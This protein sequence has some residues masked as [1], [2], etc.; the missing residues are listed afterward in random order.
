M[1]NNKKISKSITA[2]LFAV[3]FTSDALASAELDRVYKLNTIGVL[4]AWDNVD[5]L[6]GD[7][8][9]DAYQNNLKQESRF[10]IQDLSKANQVLANS[11]LPYNKLIEDAEILKTMAEKY[12]LDS[13]LRTKVYKEGPQYRFVI[14]WIHAPKNQLLSSET[15]K[16]D[17]P[18]EPGTNSGSQKFKLELSHALDRVVKKVPFFGNVTGRDQ[19]S[20]TVNVGESSGIK[21]GDTLVLATIDEV[22]YHPLLKS[23]VDWR[24]SSTGKIVIKDVDEGMAFG[25]IVS[26]DFGRS[27]ARNQKI[28]QWMAAPDSQPNIEKRVTDYED[29]AERAGE[30][31]R[32]G[33]AAPGVFIG[34]Y[35]HE[36]TQ[37]AGGFDGGGMMIGVKADAQGWIT[38]DWF[39][40]LNLAFGSAGYSQKVITTQAETAASGVNATMSQFRLGVGYFYHPTPNFFGPKGWAKLGFQSTSF[41]LPSNSTEQTSTTSFSSLTLGIGGDLP[42]RDDYGALLSINFGIFAGGEESGRFQTGTATG[43]TSVD[44]YLGGYYWIQP[45]M[46]LN[47]G[48][49]F[50]SYSLDFATG[51][52][53][54]KLIALGPTMAFY[55]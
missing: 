28:V 46:K 48:I 10:T 12:K 41:G 35:S 6:F 23:I 39:A 43:A 54:N 31:P 50:K 8:V 22:K 21:K 42:I 16:L 47:V 29:R 18:F 9:S 26:E 20:V 24:L 11:T 37:G 45:K 30:P 33:W 4:R 25:Q 32:L 40:D 49:D 53:S 14:D 52:I 44:F 36:W 34:S 3:L 13:F 1:N 38:A 51:S 15:F 2:F 55:F 27:I 17:E 5:G 7:I 19:N